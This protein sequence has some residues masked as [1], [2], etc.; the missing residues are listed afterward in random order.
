MIRKKLSVLLAILM[1]SATIVGT[2][3]KTV[4]ASESI[5]S[6]ESSQLKNGTYTVKNKTA[7]IDETNI[8][9]QS[10]ARN[11]LLEDSTIN[12]KDGIIKM[13]V[14]FNSQMY[15]F[16][17][18]INVTL[19]GKTLESI[20]NTEEQSLTF[21]IPSI[22]SKVL[23]NMDVSVMGRTV[24][25]YL[26]N[27]INTLTLVKEDVQPL[28]NGDYTL[29]NDV[30][31]YKEGATT[32][33]IEH[34]YSSARG[35]LNSQT[36]VNVQNGKIMMTLSFNDKMYNFLKDIRVSLNG[37]DLNAINDTEAK[38]ISFEV[39]SL[40]SK[41]LL[42]M[43]ITMMQNDVS[44]YVINDE[45]T[46]EK[47]QQESGKDSNTD[48]NTDDIV[49]DEAVVEDGSVTDNVKEDVEGTGSIVDEE[50]NVV[51]KITVKE[52][53]IKNNVTH[54]NA[55]GVS[56]SRKYLDSTSY[57]KEINGKYYVTLK[58]TGR[59][60]M[61]NHQI[62][63]NGNLVNY[64]VV[65]SDSDTISLRFEVASLD[66]DIKV[67]TYVVPM[68]RNVEFGV[69]LLKDTLTLVN[70]YEIEPNEVE[71]EIKL[72]KTG[73]FSGVLSILGLAVASA[74]GIISR[75]RK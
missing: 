42:S 4:Y 45:S 70:E 62:Y 73:D 39:P 64:T 53:T 14:K 65:S 3:V 37:V 27:D 33:E 38:T 26:E 67:S 32:S 5:V 58:F 68:G 50:S 47:A 22:D 69:Q 46:L 55:T 41:V 34:G 17:D 18:N 7:Y 48:N 29:S 19:N 20:K 15:K 71:K 1:I 13:T 11:V 60:F 35:V 23:M 12:V 56:M 31:Y 2:N 57:V 49:K 72:P 43:G 63:V 21:D 28:E 74:G 36:K 54:E 6:S 61:N 75:K 9:G 16:L 52:Y 59:E 24:S 10:M 25:F 66:D 8:T 44:F 51:E 30:E 40:S